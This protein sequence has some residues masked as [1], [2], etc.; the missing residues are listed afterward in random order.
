VV[1]RASGTL[2]RTTCGFVLG[3]AAAAAAKDGPLLGEGGVAGAGTGLDGGA[4]SEAGGFFFFLPRL[5]TVVQESPNGLPVRA[6]KS[7]GVGVEV[8]GG[9][10]EMGLRVVM[11]GSEKRT[12][13]TG[14]GCGAGGG[15]YGQEF[16]EKN[17]RCVRDGTGHLVFGAKPVYIVGEVLE[18]VGGSWGIAS[19]E[20]IEKVSVLGGLHDLCLLVAARVP[21]PGAMVELLR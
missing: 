18:V 20:V 16:F 11:G 7:S 19:E 21:E 14:L 9:G 5:V 6:G 15:G 17:K 2:G 10:S 12:F 4:G 3:L 13:A 1:R 8:V